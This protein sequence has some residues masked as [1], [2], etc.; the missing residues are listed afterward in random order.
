MAHRLHRRRECFARPADH[1]TSVDHGTAFDIAGRNQADATNMKS[2]MRLAVNMA[3]GKLALAGAAAGSANSESANAKR[4]ILEACANMHLADTLI[5]ALHVTLVGIGIRVAGRQKTTDSYFIARAQRSRLGRGAFAAGHH[6][7]HLTFIAFPRGLRGR[8]ELLVPGILFVIVILSIAHHRAL[9]RHAVSMSVYEYSASASVPRSACILLSL[10]PQGHFAKM[11]FVFTCWRSPS[12]GLPAGRSAFLIIGLGVITI[13]LH[14]HRRPSRLIWTDVV[15]GFLL[16]TGS[17][18]RSSCCCFSPQ[19]HPGAMIHSLPAITKTSLAA[20]ISTLARPPS[21]PWRSTALRYYLQKYTADQT[22][23]QRYLAAKSDSSL[24]RGIAMGASLCLPVWTAFMLIGS[25]ALASTASQA[26]RFPRP[27]SA[28]IRFFPI[29][30]SRRC[31]SASPA[32]SLPRSS[33]QHVHA[34][35]PISTAW[36]SSWLKISTRTSSRAQRR[37]APAFR[38]NRCRPLRRSRHRGRPP[39]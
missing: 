39:P 38:Q 25:A 33:A 3:E 36:V 8:L 16:W 30:W 9:F 24:L 37:A 27:S 34:R 2:A 7:H 4:Q 31:P 10:L 23:V 17:P 26:S 18:S 22:V 20:S 12:R 1:R 5:I 19:V 6:H 15:Q 32:S 29:T 11:G 28:P 13:F 14:V 35:F 21:G